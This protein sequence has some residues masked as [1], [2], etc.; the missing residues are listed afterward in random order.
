MVIARNRARCSHQHST[1]APTEP[2]TCKAAPASAAICGP[3][4]AAPTS[5]GVQLIRKK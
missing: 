2:P 1:S 3:T 5:V 4:L